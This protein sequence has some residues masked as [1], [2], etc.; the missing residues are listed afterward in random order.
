MHIDISYPSFYCCCI[1]CI[2]IQFAQ[3]SDLLDMLDL[4]LLVGGGGVVCVYQK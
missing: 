2:G 4:S 3:G 1:T